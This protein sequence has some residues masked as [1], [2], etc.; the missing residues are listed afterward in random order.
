[1]DFFFFRDGN[2][3]IF[4]NLTLPDPAPLNHQI[5]KLR[6]EAENFLKKINHKLNH[7]DSGDADGKAT[8][9][10]VSAF[11]CSGLMLLNFRAPG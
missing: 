5:D 1:M 11:S 9:C 10:P 2:D 7:P 6:Q 4:Q 8:A 3:T